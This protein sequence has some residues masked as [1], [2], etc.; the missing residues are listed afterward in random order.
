MKRI[1]ISIMMLAV[2]LSGKMNVH[3]TEAQIKVELRASKS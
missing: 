2:M 3:A 1:L